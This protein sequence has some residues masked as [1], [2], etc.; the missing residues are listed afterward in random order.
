[1]SPSAQSAVDERVMRDAETRIVV[2]VV[3]ASRPAARS[4]LHELGIEKK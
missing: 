4:D 3:S 1:M 2:G